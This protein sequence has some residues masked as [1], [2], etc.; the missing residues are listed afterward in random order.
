MNS[1]RFEKT[2]RFR[3]S[4]NV[5]IYFEIPL[6]SEIFRL[7]IQRFDFKIGTRGAKALLPLDNASCYKIKFDQF[8]NIKVEFFAPNMT[9]YLQPLDMGYFATVKKRVRKYRRTYLVGESSPSLKETITKAANIRTNFNS[10]L[11]RCFWKVAG[12]IDATESDTERIGEILDLQEHAISVGDGL[13]TENL[14]G[15]SESEESES[16]E[17]ESE[18]SESEESESEDVQVIDDGINELEFTTESRPPTVKSTTNLKQSQISA[19]FY[20]NK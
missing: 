3:C 17:N 6:N 1:K 10:D 13:A 2:L 15:N 12:L 4:R 20:K 11:V 16:D 5:K 14:D 19:F 7:I 18:E 8:K 9:G